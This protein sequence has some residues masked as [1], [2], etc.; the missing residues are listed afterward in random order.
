MN[1][2]SRGW[3]II[4]D[5]YRTRF[6]RTEKKP[7]KEKKIKERKSIN[8]NHCTLS[9][10]RRV[11]PEAHLYTVDNISKRRALSNWP[12]PILRGWSKVEHPQTDNGAGGRSDTTPR[13]SREVPKRS[14]WRGGFEPRRTY[15]SR[16]EGRTR[17]RVHVTGPVAVNV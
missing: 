12:A 8:A 16:R 7:K 5:V 1:V 9:T 17:D 10:C 11:V 15:S 4:E 3:E 6:K 14:P 13:E 2:K